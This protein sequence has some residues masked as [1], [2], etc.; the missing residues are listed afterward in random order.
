MAGKVLTPSTTR[1]GATASSSQAASQSAKSTS[2]PSWYGCAR[3][4][5]YNAEYDARAVLQGQL[6]VQ[7]HCNTAHPTV[8][9]TCVLA[10][11]RGVPDGR[12]EAY[13]LNR[14][15]GLHWE[16]GLLLLSLRRAQPQSPLVLR[17]GRLITGLGRGRQRGLEDDE[18]E[19]DEDEEEDEQ[20]QYLLK[21]SVG[22]DQL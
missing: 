20:L 7:T 4:C 15:G 19:E 16:M 12:G 18:E 13:Q 2:C 5:Q 11:Q 3:A 6:A 8:R 9:T 21:R 17:E 22:E 1:R 10:V 14:R